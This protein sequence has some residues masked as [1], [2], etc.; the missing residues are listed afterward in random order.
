MKRVSTPKTA[1]RLETLAK[2]AET[3]AGKRARELLDLIARRMQRITEDFYDIGAALRELHEKKLFAA[4]GFSSLAE[5]LKAHRLMSRSRA[6]EL[7]HIVKTVPRKQALTLGAEKS[8]AL[9]RLTAATKELDTVEELATGGLTVRGRKRSVEELSVRE[10]DSTARAERS[11]AE[12]PKVD[13]EAKA[14]A[15]S[16]RTI[17][18]ALRKRGAKSATVAATK[19]AGTWFLEIALPLANRRAL[20][21]LAR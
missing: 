17:Q 18:A 8:Y 5:L 21:A 16:A 3:A 13:P 20:G 6:F 15:Q 11:K 9:A 12:P 19:R 7:M 4:L 14:A 2:T 10:I 1:K